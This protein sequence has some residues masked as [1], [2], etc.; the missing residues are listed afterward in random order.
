MK[1]ALTLLAASLFLASSA[2]FADPAPLIKASAAL[3]MAEED[4][5]ERGLYGEIY[6]ASINLK[7]EGVLREETY[8]EILWN[9]SFPATETEG[10]KEFG[11]KVRMDGSYRRMVRK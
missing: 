7:T 1:I 11:A 6:P 5:E 8:W 2:A 9:K 4:L 3:T 10:A